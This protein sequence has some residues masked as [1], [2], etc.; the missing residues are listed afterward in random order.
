MNRFLVV[1]CGGSGGATLAY[2]MDQLRS[3]L[4]AHGVHTLPRGWQFVHMDVPHTEEPGPEGVGNVRQQGGTYLGTGPRDAVYA[5]LDRAVSKRFAE[6]HALDSIATWA[7]REPEKVAI[8]ITAGAGQYRAVGRLITLSR[9]G[10]IQ[11]VLRTAWDELNRVETASE[12]SALRVPGLGDYDAGPPLVFVVSSMAGGAGASMALDICRLLTL[13]PGV[14]PNLVGVFMVA[15]NI[16]DMIPEASRTGVRPNALAMLGEIVAAQTGAAKAHDTAALQALGLQGGGDTQVPFARV[17]PVG[18][19]AGVERTLFGSGRPEAVYRGL[20]RGLAGMIM[21]GTATAQFRGYDLANDNSPD[22]DR[23]QLGWGSS[24]RQLAWGSY[25]F[26]GLSMG[27]DRYAE[28]AAQRL[29]AGCVHRLLDGHL[30][31]GNDMSADDQVTALLDSQWPGA[32]AR[33]GLPAPGRDAPTERQV[34]AWLTQQAFP[35]SRVESVAAGVLNREVR[36]YVP[37]PTGQQTRQW[38]PVL[39]SQLAQRRGPLTDATGVEAAALAHRWHQELRG[40]IEQEVAEATA[41]LGL[42]FAAALLD[43]LGTHL[44][45]AVVPGTDQLSRHAPADVSAIPEDAAHAIDAMSRGVVQNGGA[46]VDQLLQGYHEQVRTLVYATVAGLVRDL[47]DAMVVDVLEPL[48]KAVAEAQRILTRARS[49]PV[50]D[51]GLARLATDECSAWPSDADERV[52]ARF[53]QADNEVLLTT[54]RD[55]PAQ[56]TAHVRRAVG[57]GGAPFEQARDEVVGRILSGVWA[58][59][60][61]EQAPGS[62]LEVL[63]PWR[64]SVFAVEPGTGRALVP[65]RARYD[66]HL[67]PAELLARARAFV[68]RRGESFDTFCR[69]SISDYVRG[70]TGGESEVEL[71]DRR[72]TV[73]EKFTEALSLARPLISV[74]PAALQ[75]VH[76]GVQITYR[77]KFSEVPFA[78]LLI[79]DE[80]L[81]VVKA[82]TVIDDSSRSNLEAALG[83]SNGVTRID[84]FGSYPNYSP[85]VFDGVLV[86]VAEQWSRTADMGREAFWRWRRSRP[87]DAALP[88][89]DDERRAMIGGWLIGQLIGR[90]A[91]PDP[92]FRRPVQIWDDEAGDTGEWLDF[93][94]PLLTPP[95]RFLVQYDWLPAVLESVLLAIARSHEPPVMS[96]L[97]PYQVL[98]GLYDAT[99]QEPVGGIY[100]LSARELLA[101]WVQGKLSGGGRSRVSGAELASTPDERADAA[102]TWLTTIRDTSRK[103]LGDAPGRLA[104]RAD[105]A[106]TPMFHDLA[107]DVNRMAGE[108]IRIIGEIPRDPDGGTGEGITF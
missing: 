16:F 22:G 101:G 62:P 61:A 95:G 93:P 94:H 75:A 108:I 23:N 1:G 67:R 98:R 90:I 60:D 104:R 70:T 14:D 73:V 25:G 97:R 43:R 41:G 36:D 6:R 20:G 84:V 21:S 81:D 47:L 29:A 30:Q 88:M 38:E 65:S 80:L 83:D 82:N 63:A 102:V 89:G 13:V 32:C 85:L 87:L 11:R 35:R 33:I 69:L 40:R 12:M 24:W 7:P 74:D 56:Y 50:S 103:D 105:A 44:R 77:Y 53:D 96:S 100:V 66:L 58:T 86:P 106:R 34:G 59:V 45:T 71:A 79:A 68:A 2:L 48:T 10:E 99:P 54:S 46:L 18:R 28:Y 42:S 92:P 55:F 57:G 91:L 5:T 52:P 19:F 27:R 3:D 4:G 37:D 64:S 8:P 17:F 107:P 72:R 49:A 31:P 51:L 9:V 15:P 39:R 26:A 76:S 78:G